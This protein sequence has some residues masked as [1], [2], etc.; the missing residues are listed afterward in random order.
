LQGPDDHDGAGDDD[1]AAGHSVDVHRTQAQAHTATPDSPGADGELLVVGQM[2]GGCQIRRLLGVGGMS[3]VYLASEMMLGRNVALKI[4]RAGVVGAAQAARIIEEA[5]AIAKVSHP[6]IVQLYYCEEYR[7]LPYLALEYVK[8]E[9]LHERAVRGA[10]SRD[11]ILRY[12]R[13]IADALAHA[14]AHNVVHCDLKPRNVMLGSDGR[15]RVVDFGIAQSAEVM[16]HRVEGTPEWMA[17]EQW[18]GRPLTDR[19]DVWALAVIVAQLITGSH[20]LGADPARRRA[21]CIDPDRELELELPRQAELPAP[22]AELVRRSL[23]RSPQA[24]PSAADWYRVL[25]EVISGRAEVLLDEPYRGLNAF[26][27]QH[28]RYFFGREA[29]VDT[30][31]ERL[32]A[33][34]CLPIVGPSGVG[35]SSF[36]HAGVIPRLRA[37]ERWT[38]ISFRPGAAPIAA[39]ARQLV[40]VVGDPRPH[41]QAE[42]RREAAALEDELFKQPTLLGIRLSTLVAA[43]ESRILLVVDQFEEVF[44]HG[45]SVE[46]QRRFVEMLLAAAD[47]AMDPVRV[48]FTLRED[49]LG[50]IE[51]L[52]SLFVMRRMSA[53]DLTRTIVAPLKRYGFRFDS[54]EV[55]AKMLREVASEEVAALPLLQFACKALWDVRDDER[56][57]L[58][59]AKYEEM[60]GIGGALGRHADEVLERFSAAELKAARHLLLQLVVGNARRTLPQSQLVADSAP[61]AAAVLAYLEMARLVVVRSQPD[62]DD[63]VVEIAHESLLSKWPRL[64]AW[65]EDSRDERRLL[66]ELDDAATWWDRH[67]RREELT[68]SAGQ[69]E[70]TRRRAEGHTLT[71][72]F[73]PLA[74]E[75]LAAAERHHRAQRRRRVTQIV[76]ATA[77]VSVAAVLGI[78][79]LSDFRNRQD[80]VDKNFGVVDFELAPF[81]YD[82][83][84]AVAVDA[85][86]L[87]G[88]RWKLFT[89]LDDETP[90]VPLPPSLVSVERRG[91]HAGIRTDRVEAP[92]GLA[93]LKL[94]GRG[95]RGEVCGISWIRLRSLPGY[96]RRQEPKVPRWRIA[97]PTCRATRWSTIEI[98]AGPFIYGGP[99][100]PASSWYEKKDPDYTEPEVTIELPT[101][102]ID[103][104]EVS[105]G[106]YAP[107]AAMASLTGYHPP[108][109]ADDQ[110]HKDDS[111]PEYPVTSIDAWNA[112]AFCR[113]LGKDLP[114]DAQWVKAARGGLVID[115]KPNPNPKRLY[116]SGA[117]P[118]P[119]CANLADL[120]DGYDWAAP[121][122]AFECGAS[123]YGVLNQ[124]GN[125]EE[126]IARNGQMDRHGNALWATRAGSAESPLER[127]QHTTV[128]RNHRQSTWT[129]YALGMRCA[130]LGR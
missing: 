75:F 2:V 95:R 32:R 77:V 112:Q 42:Q 31:L 85:D 130:L 100:V 3:R 61:D 60:G 11:E 102:A 29:E 109:Y 17:P 126:W 14:H 55:I 86:E 105:N 92:G 40:A 66:K 71:L 80:K 103:R 41:H 128:F 64:A 113:F 54:D 19:V 33:A 15:L 76:A 97:V 117:Q 107:F 78:G 47:D 18:Q 4:V 68:W 96:S 6:H 84:G 34:P 12:A 79:W 46:V 124:V 110:K 58:L 116:P 24:R 99:G 10:M 13:S 49:F 123:P 69:V 45:A 26:G 57:L 94:E 70:A 43:S 48:V 35:K 23:Q 120:Q 30:Y 127:E 111:G 87:P 5:R 108:I 89:A 121:V 72:K 39:L 53:D 125:V 118:H 1:P 52:S 119:A 91:V 62:S 81:D 74:E 93:F 98:E 82:E 8:G 122:T 50:K 36:L 27:E 65:L 90:G 115:G 7:G 67:Q 106:A 22:V 21:L 101:F 59:Q 16:D 20:P 44:T 37:R 129:N 63:K 28:A 38:V 73:S 9:S 56:R 83:R 88:L 25:D 104:T 114:S 51:G